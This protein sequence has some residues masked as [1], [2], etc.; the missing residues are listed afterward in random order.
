VRE[1]PGNDDIVY[2]PLL[3]L[4]AINAGDKK[5]TENFFLFLSLR[6]RDVKRGE[7]GGHR[8]H[9]ADGRGGKK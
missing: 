2:S 3:A 6:F 7:R 1:Y 9:A 8:K 4:S 5:T